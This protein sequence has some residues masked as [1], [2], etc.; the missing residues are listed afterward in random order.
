MF[1]STERFP[2]FDYF[3]VPYQVDGPSAGAADLPRGVGR[4]H[5]DHES[6]SAPSLY[7]WSGTATHPRRTR[8]GRF[9]LAGF[10][11]V[12]RVLREPPAVL[13]RQLGT[14]RW[15]P[16]WPILD[17]DGRTVASVWSDEQG[18]VFLPFDPGEAMTCLWSER[19]TRLG[20]SRWTSAVRGTLVKGYYAVRPLLPRTVQ[21]RLRQGYA[22]HRDLPDF[23]GWPAE[24]S[25]H[26]LY[27]WLWARLEALA[28]EPVPYLSPWPRGREA[29]LV[30]TH[31]VETAA[32]RD[33][34]EVLR[35]PERE[36]GLRSS[37]NFVPLRY[38]VPETLVRRLQHEGCE[39]GVHGLRHDG[40]DLASRRKLRR[41]LP[42][43]RQYAE[44]WG[45]VGFRSPA[46]QRGWSLMPT[47]G[48]DYDSSYTDTAPHE[49]QPGG[50]CTYLPFFNEDLVE[51]PMTLAM[52]HTLFEILGHT[53]GTVWQEK[54][55]DLRRRGGMM[56]VLVHP[57][58]AGCPGLLEAWH[59][60]LERFAHDDA[61]WQP[62]PREVSAWWRS[63]AASGI[64]RVDGAWQVYGPAAGEAE[65]RLAGAR[66][67][68]DGSAGALGEE[69][70][71]RVDHDI[72][73]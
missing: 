29:A 52:D 21:I 67:R 72:A 36:L 46:T 68:E 38:D 18:N 30:L 24:H 62:L 53:D 9:G 33:T 13:S 25:L 44:R 32:G 12:C 56:L 70:E 22:A 19:Y 58:Y 37:W 40:Q 48:F 47:M 20:L 7:W 16:T 39:V 60:L 54:A 10:T 31:D 34:I 4:L 5:R 35:G 63:R 51:L 65:I 71:P 15:R 2:F 23:P 42:Q 27:D 49:P 55:E 3:R 59:E 41:R 64:E 14:A 50:C 6:G 66:F 17:E 45:A 69:G 28:G 61:V 43:M 57:D 11:L 26:D 8:A 1:T 73:G